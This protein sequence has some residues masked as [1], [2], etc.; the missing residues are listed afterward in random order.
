MCIVVLLLV[1]NVLTYK[2]FSDMGV[3]INNIVWC[4]IMNIVVFFS[5][6]NIKFNNWLNKKL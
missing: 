1:S 5:I 2:F 6:N 4:F 3:V